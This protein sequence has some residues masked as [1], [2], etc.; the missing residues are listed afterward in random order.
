MADEDNASYMT[1]P[2]QVDN[3]RR[4]F[5]S[6]ASLLSKSQ[7][8]LP[9]LRREFRGE[10]LKQYEDGFIESVQTSKPIF[11]EVDFETNKAK[12]IKVKYKDGTEAEIYRINEEAVEEILSMLK[13]LGL[14]Q[15]T[16][17]TNVDEETVLDDL[18]EFE[19]K[20]AALLAQKQKGW[21]LD[22]ELMPI[23]MTKIKTIV[24]DARYMCVNGSTIKAIQKAVSRVEHSYEGDNK[25]RSASP[26]G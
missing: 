11:V 19:M 24:Q 14:N 6:I 20:L 3:T 1:Y 10:V 26:Y 8:L 9:V 13:F 12:K 4:E 25:K 21:G 5:A 23:L 7:D 22:K 16:P 2:N 18:R 17:M 15:I